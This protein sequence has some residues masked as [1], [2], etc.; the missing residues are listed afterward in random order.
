MTETTRRANAREK[1]LKVLQRQQ[2]TTNVR[3]AKVC[4][5][6]GARLAELRKAGWDIPE[7]EPIKPGVFRYRLIGRSRQMKL[8]P[9]A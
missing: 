3:L 4:Q 5:R 6:F 1:I 2:T 8:R 9:A 7:P